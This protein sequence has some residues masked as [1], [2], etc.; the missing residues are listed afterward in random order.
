MCDFEKNGRIYTKSVE[1]EKIRTYG[2]TRSCDILTIGGRIV[3]L[4]D[5]EVVR[6]AE[7]SSV[8]EGKLLA[9]RQLT[10]ASVAREAGQMINPFSGP[11]HPIPGAHA[12]S[13]FRALCAESST[14]TR[15]ENSHSVLS[16]KRINCRGISSASVSGYR[17][18]S[19]F[20]SYLRF[21]GD[22][23]CS[24]LDQ[25]LRSVMITAGI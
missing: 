6:L 17:D 8:H 18:V 4:D 11:S 19:I 15:S 24:R 9:G 23:Q 14:N 25:R 7:Q 10:R 16:G 22:S 2:E 21:I 12:A 1:R 5:V 3:A 20:I 13:A